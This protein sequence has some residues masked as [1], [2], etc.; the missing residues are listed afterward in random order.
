[1]WLKTRTLLILIIFLLHLFRR[2]NIFLWSNFL[3]TIFY[4]ILL[5]IQYC[6]HFIFNFWSMIWLM[7]YYF[8]RKIC[9][10][11]WFC[12]IIN[13]MLCFKSLYFLFINLIKFSNLKYLFHHL[14]FDNCWL[15][16][17]NN[18]KYF[19]NFEFEF[20]SYNFIKFEFNSIWFYFLEFKN[21]KKLFK[22]FFK[23][24]N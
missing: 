16:P 14:F 6:M 5:R 21:T 3:N 24:L 1:L 20:R 19:K 15:K 17:I 10:C 9:F 4:L 18:W 13:I 2:H 23:I 12:I 7:F 8:K 22:W 11:I